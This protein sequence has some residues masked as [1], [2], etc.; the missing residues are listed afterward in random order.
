M[1][2]EATGQGTSNDSPRG[3]LRVWSRR[4]SNFED[5]RPL[6][7]SDDY[8]AA[9]LVTTRA[10]ATW[11]RPVDVRGRDTIRVYVTFTKVAGQTSLVIAL[12]SSPYDAKSGPEWFDRYGSFAHKYG[13]AVALPTT[14]RDLTLD[15]SG[16]ANGEHRISF[17]LD[18]MENHMRFKPYGV[19]TVT[20]SR[21]KIEV[22]REQDGT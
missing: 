13:D 18:P 12:Q 22:V 7:V 9:D 1:S 14:P 11:G 5:V 4:A 2:G 16:F 19:G 3:G 20:G 8:A 10:G 17:D 6:V 15:V 21:C